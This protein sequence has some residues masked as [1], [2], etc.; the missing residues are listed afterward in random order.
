MSKSA[1]SILHNKAEGTCYL[2]MKLHGDYDRRTGLEEHHVFMGNQYRGLSD[3]YGLKVY[4]CREHHRI[5]K[6]SVHQNAEISRVVQKDAQKAF[7]AK[8]SHEEWRKVFGR[9]FL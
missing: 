6:E 8:Y 3:R 5:S 4:L 2:C 9:S 7:E 1:P